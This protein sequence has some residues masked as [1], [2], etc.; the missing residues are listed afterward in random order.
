M[1]TRELGVPAQS[2][3][4]FLG[5]MFGTALVTGFLLVGTIHRYGAVRVL[6]VVTP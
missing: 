4:L 6:Q 5:T 1:I 3:G 2:V